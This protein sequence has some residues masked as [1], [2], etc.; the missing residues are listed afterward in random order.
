MTGKERDR[1]FKKARAQVI[2]AR[3][4]LLKGTRDE[5]VALLND[6]AAQIKALLAGQPS[7]YQ[8][9]YLPQLQ[10][11]IQTALAAL[12]AKSAGVIA[13]KSGEAWALGQAMIEKPLEAGGIRIIGELPMLD[14]RPLVAMRTFM[15][16]RIQD[17]ASSAAAK[18]N[19]ELGLVVIGGQSPGDAIANITK[20][21]KEQSRR[22]AT[23]I[24]RTEIGRVF[25]TA[26]HE[27][28]QQAGDT[29]PGLKKQWRRSGKIHSRPQHD[30]ADG[31]IQPRDRPFIIGGHQLM[32]PHDPKAP[33]SETINCGCVM[34]PF[35][36]SWDVSIPGKKPF[37]EEEIGLNP[38]KADMA[39]SGLLV[40]D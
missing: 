15:T 22:R 18:I 26:A 32:Y 35:M 12:G 10:K 3:T 38:T 7:D 17:V 24:V 14:T 1:R 11:E 21:L 39:T 16:D 40:I 28:L 36:E 34:L 27:R 20:L 5:I 31:Q 29:V 19:G 33:A 9:W 8:Q 2:K 13:T 30:A 6:V 25:A 37:S 4:G 23:T